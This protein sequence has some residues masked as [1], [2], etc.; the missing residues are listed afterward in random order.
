MDRFEERLAEVDWWIPGLREFD[1]VLLLLWIVVIPCLVGW[2]CAVMLRLWRARR[3][4][5]IGPQEYRYCLES[6]GIEDDRPEEPVILR[7]AG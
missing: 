2:G 6:S 4:E 3:A 1:G 5:D 7:K